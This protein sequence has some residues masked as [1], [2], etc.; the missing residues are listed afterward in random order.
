MNP[1]GVALP[2]VVGLV[3]GLVGACRPAGTTATLPASATPSGPLPPSRAVTGETLDVVVPLLHGGSV[4]T[5]ALRGKVVVLELVD[6]EHVDAA[7]YVDYQRLQD[8]RP[9]DVAV[10]LVSLD[11]EGWT[12]T[13]LPF[14]LGWDPQG[15]LAT[16]LRAA[17]LPTVIVLDRDGRVVHQYGG[18]RARSQEHALAAARAQFGG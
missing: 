16:R 17:R 18:E 2:M 5:T 14:V 4:T 11:P 13:T 15:A 12:D 8:E 10:L 9:D 7:G 3:G 6:A 1:R